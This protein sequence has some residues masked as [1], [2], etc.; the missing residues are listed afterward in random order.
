[1]YGGRRRWKCNDTFYIF[2]GS[3]QCLPQCFLRRPRRGQANPPLEQDTIPVRAKK[4]LLAVVGWG[5]PRR[6]PP[7][8]EVNVGPPAASTS[9][10]NERFFRTSPIPDNAPTLNK[11]GQGRRDGTTPQHDEKERF[12]RSHRITKF[13]N[14]VRCTSWHGTRDKKNDAAQRT[15]IMR[16]VRLPPEGGT[17]QTNAEP[18]QP[19]LPEWAMIAF[20]RRPGAIHRKLTCNFVDTSHRP[21]W[22]TNGRCDAQSASNTRNQ[23]VCNQTMGD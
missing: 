16:T 14:R 1:M 19:C 6:R 23:M 9:D 3:E 4:T 8:P 20:A 17:K 11:R 13:H 21:Q 22:I 7:S 12:F 15:I 2:Y 18:S 5:V 10:E